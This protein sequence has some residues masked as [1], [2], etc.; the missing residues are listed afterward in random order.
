MG[1]TGRKIRDYLDENID[2]PIFNAVADYGIEPLY[3]N[4]LNPAQDFLFGGESPRKELDYGNFKLGL[5]QIAED[6][7]GSAKK[8]AISVAE[9]PLAQI[10]ATQGIGVAA[11]GALG[12]AR[13]GGGLVKGGLKLAGKA[14]GLAGKAATAS[15]LATELAIAGGLS[16]AQKL[17]N[18]KKGLSPEDASAQEISAH[19]SEGPAQMQGP[20][21][22][23]PGIDRKLTRQDIIDRV[24]AGEP[25]Q[26]R[27]DM[28]AEDVGSGETGGGT[29]SRPASKEAVYEKILDA[30]ER[31]AAQQ[32]MGDAIKET[33]GLRT[34]VATQ[35]RGAKTP[36][37]QARVLTS[38]GIDATPYITKEGRET[39]ID[40]NKEHGGMSLAD[41]LEGYFHN[42]AKDR[43]GGYYNFPTGRSHSGEQRQQTAAEFAAQ[44][45]A[46]AS[47][48]AAA[49]AGKGE[50]DGGFWESGGML[51]ALGTAGAALLFRKQIG[52]VLGK[53]FGKEAAATVAKDAGE[54]AGKNLVKRIG[55]DAAAAE[56]RAA[57]DLAS[58]IG[59]KRAS[60]SG[61]NFTLPGEYADVPAVIQPKIAPQKLLTQSTGTTTAEETAA[62]KLSAK[63][64][65]RRG[66]TPEFTTGKIK[67]QKLHVTKDDAISAKEALRKAIADMKEAEAKLPTTKLGTPKLKNP[68]PGKFMRAPDVS[69]SSVKAAARAAA[70]KKTDAKA[71]ELY[72]QRTR[73]VDDA[74]QLLKEMQDEIKRRAAK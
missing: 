49:A 44:E 46:R 40:W 17:R 52:K 67:A 24:Q 33:A 36:D 30:K 50:D 56:D 58:K 4:V 13:A 15:P 32:A 28:L 72:R 8:L 48:E 61:V 5:N 25:I 45:I 62:S 63:I 47:Q 57:V 70:E 19:D 66:E 35:L 51:A 22:G 27:G 6:P 14:A 74:R 64:R 54:G 60:E 29:F 9:D 55:Y 39:K 7:T 1:D 3:N 37:E 71:W 12:A 18:K 73:A 20:D 41:H 42:Y 53:V 59:A 26:L 65:A 23:R 34:S 10:L 68:V 21:A 31:I 11:K 43:M 69:E 38:L 16:A 2:E